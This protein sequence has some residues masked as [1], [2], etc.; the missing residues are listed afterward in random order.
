MLRHLSTLIVSLG[1]SACTTSGSQKPEIDGHQE[2]L[3]TAIARLTLQTPEFGS[4]SVIKAKI[5]N[6][7]ISAPLEKREAFSG[8]AY[9]SYC[10][11]GAIENPLFPIHQQAYAEA[12][13]KERGGQRKIQIHASRLA[14]GGSG[15][16][17]FPEIEE[18]SIAR[19]RS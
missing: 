9:T 7:R 8:E 17:P 5:I 6:A 13:I 1:L 14:C 18:L 19:Y 12:Q 15:F 4:I 2:S 3:R 10:I 11:H 16:E